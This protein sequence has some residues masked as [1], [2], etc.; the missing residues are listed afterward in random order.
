MAD[1]GAALLYAVEAS[2]PFAELL[3]ARLGLDVAAS[4]E[5]QFEDGEHK[6]RPLTDPAGRDVF[7]TCSLFADAELGVDAKLCRL[8]FFCAC[9]RDAG[10]RS[11]TAL[12]PYLAYAR[13][14]RRTKAFDPVT[15]RYVAELCE[16]AGITR[17]VSLDVHNQTAFENAFR[18]PT[19]HL[20]AARL[21]VEQF[22]PLIGSA[23]VC[24]VSPDAG[25]AKRA[26]RVRQELAEA[27]G[28]EVGS[29]FLEKKRSDDVVS[30]GAVV[31]E[32]RDRVAIIV[33]DLVSTGTTLE[34]AARACV[35]RGAERVYAAVTHGLFVGDAERVI[36]SPALEHIV[37]TNSVP[38]WRLAPSLV[39]SRLRVLDATGLFAEA[40]VKVS[41]A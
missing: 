9:L 25:G 32:V 7:V 37:V 2:R 5:R 29:V 39:E 1:V 22:A 13:K 28:R 16:A 20:T 6:I 21:F 30:G 14:D 17:I 31:G 35:E 27:L 38:P 33:D 19:V 4:E 41:G 24:V 8:L 34:R 3:A 15:S 11:V 40:V 12:V 10:A 18:I 36:R 23:A 26:E